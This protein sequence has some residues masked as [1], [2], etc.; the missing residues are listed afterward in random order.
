MSALGS[1]RESASV[2]AI[3]WATIA[4]KNG[5]TQS[6]ISGSPLRRGLAGVC[7]EEDQ[8]VLFDGFGQAGD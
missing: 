7:G 1:H 2:W 6:F 4:S 3:A 8:Q 5:T